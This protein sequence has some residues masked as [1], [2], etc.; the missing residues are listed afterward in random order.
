MN[1]A[2][3]SK[4]LEQIFKCLIDRARWPASRPPIALSDLRERYMGG[5][6]HA[7]G[8]KCDRAATPRRRIAYGTDPHT[9]I[10]LCGPAAA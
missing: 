1:G 5:A 10:R 6:L 8:P 7:D 3:S 9:S 2:L 4:F